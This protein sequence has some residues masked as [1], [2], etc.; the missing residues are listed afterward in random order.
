MSAA[1]GDEDQPDNMMTVE[2]DAM[3]RKVV[4]IQPKNADPSKRSRYTR[5]EVNERMDRLAESVDGPEP[6]MQELAKNAVSPAFASALAQNASLAKFATDF[7][8]NSPAMV[9]LSEMARPYDKIA[10][11]FG[12]TIPMGF[13]WA[14]IVSGSGLGTGAVNGL[15]VFNGVKG[16]SGLGGISPRFAET[17]DDLEEHFPSKFAGMIPASTPMDEWRPTDVVLPDLGPNPV[18]ETNARVGEL[19]EIL[20]A[21]REDHLR[22][23]Q[24]DAEALAEQKRKN[25]QDRALLRISEKRRRADAWKVWVGLAAGLVGAVAG[26]LALFL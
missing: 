1:A 20:R 4:H 6:L 21:E 25:A 2:S 12:P 14:S 13:D 22:D 9:A 23:Q 15:G 24:R 8:M 16:L 19:V 17:L 5:A 11:V 10:K 18:H 3:D 7:T 26:V